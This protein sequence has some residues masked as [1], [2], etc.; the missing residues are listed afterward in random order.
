MIINWRKDE[1]YDHIVSQL[2]DQP[3]YEKLMMWIADPHDN[4][5][6]IMQ[7]I[8]TLNV[9][10]TRGFWLDLIGTIV[11]QSR[12]V[13]ILVLYRY[14][15]M[16]DG[17]FRPE[18]AESVGGIGDRLFRENDGI[19]ETTRLDDEDYR[20]LIMARVARN[21]GKV[22]LPSIT[23]SLQNMFQ[24]SDVIVKNVGIANYYAVIS[25]NV[26][27]T[28][29]QVIKSIDIIPRAAGVGNE[30]YIAPENTKFFGM[31]DMAELRPTIASKIGGIGDHL[32]EKYRV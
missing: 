32:I 3:N 21:V 17:Y 25:A 16:Q 22:D 6:E 29:K 8:S 1:A 12:F 2:H 23:L 31:S 9:Y 26:S 5:A 14:F 7:F 4:I 20:L 15:A 24:T 11:G 18:D 28:F 27:E 19:G 10:T 30:N 13:P